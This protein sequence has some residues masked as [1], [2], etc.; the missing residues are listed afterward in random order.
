MRVAA[1]QT[2]SGGDVDANLAAVEPLIAAARAQG[3]ALVV[4]PEYFGIF[5]ARA[6]DK[7]RCARSRRRRSAAGLSL[8]RR[9][10]AARVAG[11]RHGADRQRRSGARAQRFA[12]LRS[13]RTS[14]SR[15]TTRS[16]CSRSAR[17]TSATTRRGRS[18]PAAPASRSMRPCGR[19][20]LS[21]CYDL[22]FPELYRGYRRR[23]ADRRAVGVH[24][25][26][27]R[28]ALARAAQGARDREPVLR[29]RRRAGRHA[30]QRPPHL[31]PQRAD[32]SVG[33]RRRRIGRRRQASSSATSIPRGS[34]RSGASCRRWRI[35]GWPD[36]RSPL[37]RPARP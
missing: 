4:L 18:S 24:R 22:R 21:V 16:T 9:A 14:A 34:R 27:R 23:R 36:R 11:R 2:V 1:V 20:G 3:A 31:R 25:D 19:V 26:D 28:R 33:R 29:A 12:R 8:A 5:G 6:T 7:V 13:G 37:I 10:R 30:R 17:A 35:A 15:A 32:R